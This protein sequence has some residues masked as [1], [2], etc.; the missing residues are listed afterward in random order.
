MP[1]CQ[2]TDPNHF[3]PG[4]EAG[5]WLF[6]FIDVPKT[7]ALNE[8]R[9]GS[10]KHVFKPYETRTE[11][12]ETDLLEAEDGELILQVPFTESVSERTLC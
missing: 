8:R 7:S 11:A 6:P 3:H 5:Q 4:E 10:A 12:M 9:T 1:R 2:C